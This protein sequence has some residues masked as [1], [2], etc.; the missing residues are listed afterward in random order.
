MCNAA[1]KPGASCA[2][3]AKTKNRMIE[4]LSEINAKI[5]TKEFSGLSRERI[6]L[7]VP[8]VQKLL[9]KD[10]PDAQV[11][12]VK[13][14][15]IGGPNQLF[16]ICL[17]NSTDQ[18]AIKIVNKGAE[19]KHDEYLC[20]RETFALKRAAFATPKVPIVHAVYPKS[21]NLERPYFIMEC[22]EGYP[23]STV[24]TEIS[25]DEI[26]IIG[27]E[28]GEAL[29]NLHSMRFSQHGD[30]PVGTQN[31]SI[32]HYRPI[33]W[34]KSGELSETFIYRVNFVI[35]LYAEREILSLSNCEKLREIFH[36]KAKNLLRSDS[37]A[38]LVQT[39]IDSKNIMVSQ[40]KG[41]W[42]FSGLID[43]DR[44]LA[45]PPEADFGVMENRWAVG[46]SD[47]RLRIYRHF[48]TGL[49]SSYQPDDRLSEGWR[50]RM[51]LFQSLECLERIYNLG[52]RENLSG[53]I[54]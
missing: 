5:A 42:H 43:F 46:V 32:P 37:V 6:R 17:A 54:D 10:F 25:F 35:D 47:E 16:Q 9:D 53:F 7:S 27:R 40:Y 19:S 44:S 41:E 50:D 22:I 45:L 21:E 28:F 29:L 34:G 36:G 2:K 38:T 24:M 23:L 13:K 18:L 3:K 33:I 48:R 52:S 4:L 8:D 11:E 30:L 12:E 15:P 1:L 20:V 51:N 49:F 31:A 39:D 14:F 26:E